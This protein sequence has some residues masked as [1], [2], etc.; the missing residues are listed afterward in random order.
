[1]YLEAQWKN[2][3]YF[4]PFFN[5]K[6]KRHKNKQCY[7]V[8]NYNKFIP[9]PG[10]KPFS[11][12]NLS[13]I[14]THAMYLHVKYIYSYIYIK[15]HVCGIDYE[16][17]YAFIFVNVWVYFVHIQHLHLDKCH[18]VLEHLIILTVKV[19]ACVVF[20]M[21]ICV[22]LSMYELICAHICSLLYIYHRVHAYLYILVAKV[23]VCMS[24]V[25]AFVRLCLCHI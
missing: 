24:F 15:S 20:C 16:A 23:W 21:R 14:N 6:L 2:N 25:S 19:S 9:A 18:R 22:C 8:I 13:C 17:E 11:L 12:H 5:V 3:L 1:M 10:T 4:A 7:F